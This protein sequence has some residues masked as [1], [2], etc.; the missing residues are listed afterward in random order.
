MVA[1][2]QTDWTSMMQ[3]HSRIPSKEGKMQHQAN[4]L[5]K[6]CFPII[7]AYCIFIKKMIYRNLT[8]EKVC[9]IVTSLQPW[10]DLEV[11]NA[12]SLNSIDLR[13]KQIFLRNSSSL[14]QSPAAYS[15][16]CLASL[17][18]LRSLDWALAQQR[19][20]QM[21]SSLRCCTTTSSQI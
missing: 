11:C 18:V 10:L 8:F 4:L 12:Q 17:S 6:I 19:G 21:S 7:R 2:S 16:P 20:S 9:F 5:Q 15:L 1:I 14:T 3:I 13:P